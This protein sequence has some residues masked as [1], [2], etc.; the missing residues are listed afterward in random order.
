MTTTADSPGTDP[1]SPKAARTRTRVLD[2]AAH[3]LSVKG[4]AGMRLSDVASHAEVQAPAIY[5]YFPSREHLVEEVMWVGLAGMREHLAA[6]LAAAPSGVAA[7]EQIML[8]VD[9]H[10]RHELELSDYTTAVIRNGGQ[11]PER[12]RAR[13]REEELRY[14]SLWRDLIAAADAEGSLDPGLDRPLA[15][16][17]VMGA[18]N[19]AAEWWSPERGSLDHMVSVA[20]A[21][22]RNGLRGQTVPNPSGAG[23]D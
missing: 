15:Q 13:Q 1:G 6:V 4:Y 11:L 22:V 16:M 3:V 20:Q 7:M 8:A 5:Y 17:L 18:L 10:L 9:A 12:I 21:F 19:W 2:A 23:A 14:G